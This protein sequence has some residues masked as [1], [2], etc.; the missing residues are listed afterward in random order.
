VVVKR[1]KED[2]ARPKTYDAIERKQDQQ[3]GVKLEEIPNNANEQPVSMPDDFVLAIATSS[4]RHPLIKAS[5]GHRQVC[6][7]S[8]IMLIWTIGVHEHV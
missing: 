7:S 5:R 3:A 8:I 6:N 2:D 1:A 4:A